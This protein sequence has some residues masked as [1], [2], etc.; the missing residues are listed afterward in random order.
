MEVL[1]CFISGQ[2]EAQRLL[3]Y[4][5][6]TPVSSIYG[7]EYK[8]Q[9]SVHW[10]LKCGV[11]VGKLWQLEAQLRQYTSL[12][13]FTLWTGHYKGQVTVHQSLKGAQLLVNH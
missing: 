13:S 9:V 4:Y 7:R 5:A 12:F 6:S 2:L 10:G 3:G 11:A 8:G 1:E